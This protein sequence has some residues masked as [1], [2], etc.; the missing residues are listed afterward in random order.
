[1]STPAREAL[2]HAAV[3][4][5]FAAAGLTVAP[6][7]EHQPLWLSLFTGLML[8]WGGW[9]WW[10]DRRLPGRWL[11]MLLVV[12]GCTGIWFEFRTLFGRDAGVAMLVMFMAMKLLEL[13]SRR[14]GMIVVTLGYFLLLTHYF[15]S[16]SIPTGLWLL[17]ALWIVTATLVRL[18][19]GPAS[20]LR[21]TLRYAAT[22]T[23]QAIPFMLVLYLLFPRITGPLWGLPQDAHA[24]MTGLS[25]TMRP[26]SIANLA[27]RS[28]IAFRVR[29]DGEIP[30]KGKLYWR[31]PVL[32]SFDGT[33]WRPFSGRHPTPRVEAVS[34]KITYETTLEA[35]GQRWLLALDAPSSLPPE[36]SVSGTLTANH[37]Q[38]VTSRQRFRLSSSLDYRFN[39][40]EDVAVLRRNLSLPAS[41]NP[42][43]QRLAATWRSTE[44]SPDAIVGKALALFSSEFYYTLQPP[45]LGDNS[46]DDFL[47]V[48]KRGFCEHFA[49]AFVVLMRAAGIPARVVTG[50]QGGERN[51]VDEYLVV[52]QSDAHA[53][54]EIWLERRGWVR[55][56]PTAAVSPNR[57]EAGIADALP[58]GEPL[59]ALI[60]MRSAWLRTL[61][62]RWEAINN[63]WNQ[64]VI[65]Y[66]PQRQRELLSRLGLPN[67]DWQTLASL[68]GIGSGL[69][70]ATLTAWTLYRRPQHD[71]ATRLWH[72]ALRHMARRRVNCAPW[73]TPLDF[74]RRVQLEQPLM[75]E[76]FTR[77][78]EAYLQA[79][80]GKT[81]DLTTLREAIAQLP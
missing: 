50:Y 38:A 61:R 3:P 25:D 2:D 59:P 39:T 66:D 23:A 48:T 58:A 40:D 16:Q 7:F 20:T 52:R 12:I 43:T 57:I 10:Q 76:A 31:G 5:L 54:A 71:P 9:L 49:A 65:G 60:Q 6:H 75:A 27:Q 42:Q 24:G 78:V 55:V 30:A 44:K 33:T 47:F 8:L 14:D 80:Y 11:L 26:G 1:M 56:D 45:L 62:F 28:E 70:L 22:L 72:K 36:S 29:F 69:L 34:S 46:V 77:V 64:Q 51:P 41:G 21:H 73:E 53:W 17:A 67:T 81:R 68:L 19:G 35:H 18:H 79:R 32:D 74:A 15:Y 37:R 63:A 4:W 13:K